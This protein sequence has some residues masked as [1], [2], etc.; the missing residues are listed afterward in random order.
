MS[1]CRNPSPGSK[2]II[3][4]FF[5]AVSVGLIPHNH[6]RYQSMGLCPFCPRR[7]CALLDKN[8]NSSIFSDKCGVPAIPLLGMTCTNKEKPQS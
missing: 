8:P 7:I 3:S 2:N 4:G 6:Q 5:L 1:E